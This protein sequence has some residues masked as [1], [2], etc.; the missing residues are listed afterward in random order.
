MRKKFDSEFKAKV[1]L[2]ACKNQHSIEELATIYDVKADQ[3]QAWKNEMLD[4]LP[5]VF[6]DKR[7]KKYKDAHKDEVKEL[8]KVIGKL[9]VES[10]WLQKKYT[11]YLRN[12]NKK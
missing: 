12:N 7:T 2:E 1:A 4:R 11:Q 5:G 8:H 9:K 10:E 3:I 6:E